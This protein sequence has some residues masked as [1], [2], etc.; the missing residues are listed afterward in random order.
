MKHIVEQWTQNIYES[1]LWDFYFAGMRVG[2][3]DIETTG[4]DP[5]RNKF[6]LGGIY[7]VSRGEIH[8]ILAESRA[9][10]EAALEEYIRT[11]DGIDVVVTYNGRHFDMPFIDR[12]LT[13][14]CSELSRGGISQTVYDLDIYLVLSGHS[15]MRQLVP[16]LKQ[17]T[18]ENYM[19]F[20]DTRADEISGAESVMLFDHYEATGDP[21]AEKKILLHNNDDIR[22]L[23]R[24]TKA[25][26]KSDFH[27]A[28]HKL[29]FP[30]KVGEH[31]LTVS[32]IRIDKGS[33]QFSGI[34]NRSPIN[35]MGFE[36]DG[37]PATAVFREHSEGGSGTGE[38][39]INV[40]I[41]RQ[42]GIAVLDLYAFGLSEA[43]ASGITGTSCG[44]FDVYPDSGSG[45][46][47]IE[48][49][50]GI[51]HREINHFIKAFTKR[52][53]EAIT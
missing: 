9:E 33:L 31:L 27:K 40:P 12:R 11:A 38:F 25:I 1:S 14:S 53:L 44:E 20:W 5:S 49:R 17:K 41:V 43:E 36:Y 52:F 15:P 32:K 16:N 50:Q 29:G 28:L 8:Q 19:G 10:E 42:N 39:T 24:L 22:Q 51:R 21:E 7:D 46:L 13:S 47:V 48:D 4:L 6:I 3:I 18:V 26:I 34:Q 45:F 30:L 23:T 37:Q 35:Y 2:V